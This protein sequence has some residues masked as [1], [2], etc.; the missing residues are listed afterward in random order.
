MGLPTLFA[1]HLFYQENKC[2]AIETACQMV[3]QL[4]IFDNR[5]IYA[6]TSLATYIKNDK[7]AAKAEILH[8]LNLK[9]QRL[10]I[11]L[12]QLKNGKT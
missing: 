4:N 3:V 8:K 10:I 12:E 5:Q 6:N 9:K 7:V 1:I 2:T 11:E